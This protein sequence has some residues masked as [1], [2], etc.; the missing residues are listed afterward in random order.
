MSRAIYWPSVLPGLINRSGHSE[1][2]VA[3]KASFQPDTGVPIERPKGTMRIFR[4]AVNW[5]MN[6]DQ[7]RIFEDFVLDDLG[8]GTADFFWR[9]PRTGEVMIARLVGE[10]TYSVAPISNIWWRVSATIMVR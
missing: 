5:D 3:Q 1:E 10:P 4:L 9:R 2:P 6:A 8:Q 7:V